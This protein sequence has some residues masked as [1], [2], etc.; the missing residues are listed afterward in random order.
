[1]EKYDYFKAMR[2]DVLNYIWDNFT[3]D[4]IADNLENA[5][6]W[7]ERLHDEMWIA[8]SVTGNA[9]GSY[10]FS[11]WKA[12]EYICHNLDLLADAVEEFGGNIDV[13]QSGAEAC[14]VTIRCH[15]LGSVLADVLEDLKN[16]TGA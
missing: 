12:E 10:T 1:M 2:E 8:D 4:E 5:D 16:Y 15:L 3:N 14:D 13:L 11:T 7:G 9:S 6:E